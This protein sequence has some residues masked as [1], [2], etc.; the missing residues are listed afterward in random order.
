[1]GSLDFS[2]DLKSSQPHYDPRID[3][4]SNRN[5]YQETSWGAPEGEGKRIKKKMWMGKKRSRRGKGR[6]W[7]KDREEH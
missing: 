5:E 6:G 7:V 3:S 4:A 2:I 1:M